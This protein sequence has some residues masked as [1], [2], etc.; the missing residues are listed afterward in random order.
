[1]TNL[2]VAITPHREVLVRRAT[3][4]DLNVLNNIEAQCF[5]T[6]RLSKRSIKRWLTVKHGILLVAEQQG[7]VVAY[8]LVWC[9]KGTRLARLYSLAV[10]PEARGTGIAEQL[11]KQLE[12]EAQHAGRAY[13]RLEVSANNHKAIRLYQRLGYKTFG[14][15]HDY[16]GDGSEA[17]RMQ[18]QIARFAGDGISQQVPWY[19]Q[20]TEFTCG[21]AA[22]M[23]AM[24]SINEQCEPT[25]LEELAIWREATTIFMTSG[26][27]GCHPIGLALSAQYR[28]FSADVYINKREALFLEGVRSDK[29]KRI[30]ELVHNDFV[31]QAQVSG[32]DIHYQDVKQQDVEQLLQAGKRVLVL[33][34]TYRLDGKKAPHWVCITAMDTHCIYVHDPELATHQAAIDCQHVPIARAD[35][36]KM[37]SFGAAR[38]RSL[39]TIE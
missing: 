37:S 23:M 7:Q 32:V 17:L 34:S 14:A 2:A 21:P 12:Q 29:K 16:Y 39:I 18:K 8:G 5:A 35:F 22:L 25:Q 10:L 28:G 26:H 30:M 4:K 33:I 15:Y 9:L 24:A 36:D 19:M 1:M 6:D 3:N 38:L 20:T 11:L 27:G 13:L 31:N